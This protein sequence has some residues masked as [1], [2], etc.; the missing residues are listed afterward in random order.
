M[1]TSTV[2]AIVI[3]W[4]VSLFKPD[5]SKP[6]PAQL[7]AFY[8]KGKMTHLDCF[9]LSSFHCSDSPVHTQKILQ[10]LT[11]SQDHHR[12]SACVQSH[13]CSVSP[14]QCYRAKCFYPAAFAQ[15]SKSSGRFSR[16][17]WFSSTSCQSHK[18]QSFNGALLVT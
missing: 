5:W 2:S 16:S 17:G 14:T 12:L 3:V 8:P 11:V 1:S 9:L 13:T 7:A 15:I 10:L 18:Q 4:F 6:S